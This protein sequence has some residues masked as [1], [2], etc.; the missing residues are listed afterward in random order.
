MLNDAERCVQKDNENLL[1]WSPFTKNLVLYGRKYD[2]SMLKIYALPLGLC[3]FLFS[4]ASSLSAADY[5]YTL[6]WLAPNTHT[7]IISLEVAADEDGQTEFCLPAWRP[8]RYFMQHYAAALSHFE[9]LDGEGKK[10][11]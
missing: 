9:A 7:Y 6:D 10:L 4:F 11:S 3:L 8:G 1:F 2:P 5:T